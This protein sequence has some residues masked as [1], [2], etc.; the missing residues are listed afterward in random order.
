[1]MHPEES[2]R[3]LKPFWEDAD[4]NP[5]QDLLKVFGSRKM[6]ALLVLGFSSGLPLYLTGKAPLQAWLTKEGVGLGAI[7]AFGLVGLPYS[8]KFLWAPL[9]D[10]FVPPFLGRRR[11]WMLV[12]QALLLLGIALMGFQT[13]SQGLQLLAVIAVGVAFFSASQ[14]IVVDAYRSDVT[15]TVERGPGASLFLLG[16]RI[17]ILVASALTFY[18]AGFMAWNQ[19]YWVMALLM[20]VGMVASWWAPEPDLQVT[21]PRS[22][23]EAI[24]LP[25]AEFIQRNG[26]L[27]A[28]TILVFI[29]LYKLGDSLLKNVATPFLLAKGLNFAE[30][31]LAFPNALGIV[32][33]IAG[34]LAG[35]AIMTQIGINRSLWLFAGF[36]MLGNLSYVALAIVGK[37]YPLMLTAINLENFCVGLESAAFVA[38]MMSL[39][40]PAFSVT[41]YALLS[42]LQA[43]SRDILV[44]PA[45]TWA[46]NLGW[47]SFFLMTA[48]LALPGLLLLPFFAPWNEQRAD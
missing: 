30:P 43:F 21:P 19:V 27:K 34:T 2:R 9:L 38:F 26:S 23:R 10:R 31:E 44:A 46:Q 7:A 8:L 1:M 6:A 14:D 22:L 4:V 18:L 35:G 29:V 15:E 24:T 33:V 47:P 40:N 41:Q 32:A 45:G 48:L 39:C 16:Y 11:G 28:A 13:P 42:S 17:A 3:S 20:L 37:N 12:F 36:Q 5:I 25:F